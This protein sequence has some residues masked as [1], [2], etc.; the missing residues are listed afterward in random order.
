MIAID[1]NTVISNIGVIVGAIAAIIAAVH[2]RSASNNTA[3]PNGEKRNLGEIVTD[4][5]KV[6]EQPKGSK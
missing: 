6:V 4:V 1:W 5:A 3:T 2:S